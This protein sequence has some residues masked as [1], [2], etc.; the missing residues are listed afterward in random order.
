[1][2]ALADRSS[3]F[4]VCFCKGDDFSSANAAAPRRD[5]R[6]AG[7]PLADAS[8]SAIDELDSLL[9]TRDG[10]CPC[11]PVRREPFD[12]GI[13]ATTSATSFCTGACFRGS[14]STCSTGLFCLARILCAKW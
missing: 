2:A 10:I 11:A 8:R 5:C 9:K 7:M 3:S 13:S 4:D 14:S 1:M 12:F 6:F